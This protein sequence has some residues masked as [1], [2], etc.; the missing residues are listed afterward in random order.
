[1]IVIK[2]EMWPL[3]DESKAYEI[4]RGVIAND[5]TGTDERGNYDVRLLKSDVYAKRPGVWKKGRV[6]GFPRRV[7]GPWD[8]L[9]RA[10]RACV[11]DRN[12]PTTVKAPEVKL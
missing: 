11:A 5:G 12:R 7:L 6:E 9:F 8:L 10:L 4:G 1:M 3:G 2:V